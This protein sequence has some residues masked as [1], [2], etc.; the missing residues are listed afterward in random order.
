MHVASVV[1]LM[2]AP[3]AVPNG[4][5]IHNWLNINSWLTAFPH[6]STLPFDEQY[7]DGMHLPFKEHVSWYQLD[8]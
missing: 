2:I 4:S 5:M 8:H 1:R 3:Y 7:T 6:H